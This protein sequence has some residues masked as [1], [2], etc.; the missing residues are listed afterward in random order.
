[1]DKGAKVINASWGFYNYG[2]NPVPYLDSLITQVLP[3]KGILF[4][5]AA[6]NKI[7]RDDSLARRIYYDSLGITLSPEQLRDLEIHNFYQACLSAAQNNVLVVTT[8]VRLGEALESV[9]H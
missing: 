5:T 2:E 1:M 3:T 6:G 7:D 8:T 4:V 9:A